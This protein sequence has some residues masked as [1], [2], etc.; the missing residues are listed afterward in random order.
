[1]AKD[2][3][4]RQ[5]Q[6]L[7]FI[8]ESIRDRGFP[9][10]IAEIGEE[11]GISSTNGVNDHLVALEKKGFIDRSSK[12]RGIHVTEKAAA[13]LYQKDVATL[14]LLG[15]VAAGSP[16][17]AVENIEDQIPVHARY[18]R[19]GSFCLKV[20]GDSMIEDGIF[21][22]DIVV[23]DNQKR[24]AKGD[25]VVALVEDEATVK[26]YHPKGRQVELRPANSA[27]ES[28]Y[29]SSNELLVQ[30]VVVGLQRMYN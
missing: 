3:T 2:L 21:D 22:G 30:G 9:P 5:S 13:G 25:I 27:M 15:R 14:P 16:V 6:I 11:F 10:T 7:A 19:P 23:V 26:R 8:V 17:L 29:V 18:A 12:A 20:Q 1:M 4:P 28:I 24:P